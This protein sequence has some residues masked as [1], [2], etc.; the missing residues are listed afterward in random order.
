M[1][2]A[3][4]ISLFLFVVSVVFPLVVFA[5]EDSGKTEITLKTPVVYEEASSGEIRLSSVELTNGGTMTVELTPILVSIKSVGE[6]GQVELGNSVPEITDWITF[7]NSKFELKSEETKG[8]AFAIDVPEDATPGGYA[9]TLGFNTNPIHSLSDSNITNSIGV[10]A[11]L[12]INVTDD[13]NLVKS[14]RILEL[15]HSGSVF[16]P[17]EFEMLCEN[18]GVSIIL[19]VGVIEIKDM[20]NKV[21]DTNVWED[22]WLLPGTT[23]RYSNTWIPKSTFGKYTVL[24]EMVNING[25]QNFQTVS[26]WSFSGSGIVLGIGLFIFVLIFIL[27]I[28]YTLVRCL[29]RYF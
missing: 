5:Q 15:I 20:F 18:I 25:E 28:L 29:R 11:I 26:F 21:V 1:K 23:H 19:P 13:G 24:V 3:F 10:G 12:L 2:K 22:H 27:V 17:H 7:D 8:F 14:G 9:V 4:L 16:G 6:L